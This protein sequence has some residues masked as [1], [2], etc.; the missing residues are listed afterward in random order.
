MDKI[1]LRIREISIEFPDGHIIGIGGL[2]P[3]DEG[4]VVKIKGAQNFEGEQGMKE[5]F[6]IAHETTGTIAG[7]RDDGTELWDVVQIFDNEEDATKAGKVNEQMSIYQ[8]E[9]A[10]LKWLD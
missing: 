8:I 5:A 10:R 3:V 9:T 1:F 2:H 6:E 4:W 7:W